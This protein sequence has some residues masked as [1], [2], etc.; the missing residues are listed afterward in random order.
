MNHAPGS[1]GF[2]INYLNPITILRPIEFSINSP[3]NVLVGITSK[4]KMFL[5]SYIYM[6]LILDEFSINIE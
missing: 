6:Q 2:D 3:D 4:Y 1:N 5:Q